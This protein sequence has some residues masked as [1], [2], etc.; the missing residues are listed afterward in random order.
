MSMRKIYRKIAKKYGVSV[1][2]VKTEMQSAINAAYRNNPEVVKR[3]PRK[4]EIPIPGEFIG[5]AADKIAK[6]R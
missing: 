3:I 6:R 2:E 4:G 1:Q 5:Y